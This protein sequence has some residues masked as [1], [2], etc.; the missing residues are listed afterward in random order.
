[1]EAG[2][3]GEP[4]EG[5]L[6]AMIVDE[7]TATGLLLTGVGHV[8]ARRRANFLAVDDSERAAASAASL[9]EPAVPLPAPH[10]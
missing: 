4:A 1:M 10:Q 5:S 8:D 3:G 9:A 6:L 7:D 2:G